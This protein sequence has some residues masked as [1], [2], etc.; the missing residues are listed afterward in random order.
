M[1]YFFYFYPILVF[2]SFPWICCSASDLCIRRWYG[3]FVLASEPAVGPECELIVDDRGLWSRLT[4]L[5]TL[6][7]FFVE[8]L[9]AMVFKIISV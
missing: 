3:L 2:N 8:E 6:S 7:S 1:S 5:T 9:N 4:G